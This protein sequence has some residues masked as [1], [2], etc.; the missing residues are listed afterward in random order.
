[1]DEDSEKKEAVEELVSFMK[2]VEKNDEFFATAARLKKK[3]YDALLKEGFTEE[4]AIRMICSGGF[5]MK[6]NY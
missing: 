5:D 3:A 4:Q 6:L 2:E 1:M